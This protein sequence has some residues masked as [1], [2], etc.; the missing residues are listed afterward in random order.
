[1]EPELASIVLDRRDNK[2]VAN[3][4]ETRPTDDEYRRYLWLLRTLQAHEFASAPEG[5][6][7]QLVDLTVNSLLLASTESL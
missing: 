5:F 3:S 2:V 1:P 4:A 7:F 6:P